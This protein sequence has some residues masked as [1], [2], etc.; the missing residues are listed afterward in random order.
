MPES[1]YY[2][3]TEKITLIGRV[4]GGHIEGWGGDAMSLA[5]YVLQGWRD[6]PAASTIVG[7]GPRDLFTGDAL[8]GQTL[9]PRPPKCASRCASFRKISD[10]RAPCSQ[11]PV[12]VGFG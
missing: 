6:H 10:C 2:P 12:L 7:Y 1:R 3:L 9:G 11:M 5:R 4:I 8:G